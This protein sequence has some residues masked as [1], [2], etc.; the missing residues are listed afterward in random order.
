VSNVRDPALAGCPIEHTQPFGAVVVWTAR[1]LT[2]STDAV[3]HHRKA[4]E[5]FAAA[6]K[7]HTDAATHYGAGQQ[8]KAAREA[9]LAQGHVHQASEHAA[10]AAKQHARHLGEK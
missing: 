8:D 10:K 6:A 3:E 1:R 7:H 9:Y 2:M 5:H 4:A